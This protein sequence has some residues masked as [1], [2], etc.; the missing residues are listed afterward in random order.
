MED[1]IRWSDSPY[2]RNRQT[3]WRT[4]SFGYRGDFSIRRARP[5]LAHLKS[6]R[7][8]CC[9]YAS[10]TRTTNHTSDLCRPR[11]VWLCE[12]VGKEESGPHSAWFE[13]LRDTRGVTSDDQRSRVHT[14]IRLIVVISIHPHAQHPE[15]VINVDHRSP[16]PIPGDDEYCRG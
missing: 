12:R 14:R 9:R 11:V 6:P 2:S 8:Q 10:L 7:W 13:D 16:T 3:S 4:R 15:T 5:G 1:T